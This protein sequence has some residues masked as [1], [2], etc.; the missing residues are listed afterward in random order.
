[1][2][3]QPTSPTPDLTYE[4]TPV[5]TP[6]PEPAVEKKPNKILGFFKGLL[7][8]IILFVVGF[9]LSGYLRDFFSK[10][11]TT[12]SPTPML[13]QNPLLTPESTDAGSVL[14]TTPEATPAAPTTYSVLNG[15]TRQAVTDISF[16][17]PGSVLP[18]ICD[19]SACGSQGTYLPGGTRFTVA[20]RG[21]GQVLADFRGKIISDAGGKPFTVTTTTI[22][23]KPATEFTTLQTGSTIGGYSFS[24]MHGYMIE[25][26]DTL[27]LEINHFSPSGIT[28]DFAADELVFNTIIQSLTFGG[29]QKG[30][31]TQ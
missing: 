27:S 5:I 8:F 20:A 30:S 6:I 22:A 21:S 29:I 1:M 7:F 19:G 26:T 4:E 17:L 10:T 23:G 11:I 28:A 3:E 15:L 2:D 31:V 13:S 14:F 25:V 24:R 16:T 18:P 12:P 9:V